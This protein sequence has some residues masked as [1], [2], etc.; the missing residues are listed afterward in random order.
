MINNPAIQ[1]LIR[2]NSIVYTTFNMGQYKLSNDYEILEQIVINLA[3]RNVQLEEQLS[4]Y[5]R[6]YN[7]H[8]IGY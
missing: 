7:I 8:T 3:E 6:N 1:K 4:E 5:M 2:E